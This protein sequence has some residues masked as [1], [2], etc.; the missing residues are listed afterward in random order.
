MP[1]EIKWYK[2][3]DSI[4]ELNFQSN[5]M[6]VTEVNGKKVTIARFNQSLFAFAHKCPHAS[7]IMAEGY[8]NA[9][10]SVVCPLHS[11]AFSMQNGSNT[12]GEGYYLKTYL[13]E[14]RADGAYIGME[15]AG[16]F[17]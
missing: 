4:A 13:A 16:I 6:C 9:V 11:Y 10:G 5:N 15:K 2:I 12:T 1:K 8:I 3:A 14:E 7:G 17:G